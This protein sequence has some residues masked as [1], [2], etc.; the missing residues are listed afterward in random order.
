MSRKI[1]LFVVFLIF[2]GG[3]GAQEKKYP[4][5]PVSIVVGFSAGGSSDILARLLAKQLSVEM[6][7]NFIV[8]NKPGANSN[9]ANS[10]VARAKP[11]GYTLL[12]VPF[13]LPINQYL[14]KNPGYKFPDDFAPIGLLARVPN[15]IAVNAGSPIK[16]VAELVAASKKNQ[17]SYSTP[18]MGSSLHLAGELFKYETKADLLHV[19][20]KGSSPA[21]MA[22]MA[23]E[24]DTAFDNL[25]TV[26]PYLQSGKLRAVAV[27]SKIRS[28]QFSNIPTVAESGFP[29]Y[30]ISSY[31]G[32]AAPFGTDAKIIS[33][34][35]L[36]MMKALESPEIQVTLKNLGAILEKNSPEEFTR[37]LIQENKKW[38]PVIKAANIEPN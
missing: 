27:T 26:A 21:L 2:F 6:G 23:G 8:D 19:A 29:Q 11:D 37:F 7:G 35:N 20:Y 16:N 28:P 24:V 17:L 34:L 22:L 36:A 25:S 33:N 3:V 5:K 38:G 31:F 4:E 9:I 18:G 14:Y 10:F 13:G 12:L 15:V 32:L 1:T 30:E